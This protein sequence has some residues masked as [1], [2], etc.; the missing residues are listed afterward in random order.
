M[1]VVCGGGPSETPS[2]STNPSQA[3]KLEPDRYYSGQWLE[4]PKRTQVE[5][6]RWTHRNI[7]LGRAVSLDLK[8]IVVSV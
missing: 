5:T 8:S 3:K 1:H 7:D 2:A 6:G 4:E